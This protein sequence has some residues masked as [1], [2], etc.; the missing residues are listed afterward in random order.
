MYPNVY[1]CI[2]MYINVLQW[3]RVCRPCWCTK[4]E[5]LK[6]YCLCTPIFP[7]MYI[8]VHQC[9]SMYIN[10]HQCTSMYINVP[11][12]Q[13]AC[14]PCWCTKQKNLMKKSIVHVHQCSLQWSSPRVTREKCQMRAPIT[15]HPVK[16]SLD[17]HNQRPC[18][19][20]MFSFCSSGHDSVLRR[21][22][23]DCPLIDKPTTS[24]FKEEEEKNCKLRKGKKSWQVWS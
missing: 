8:N 4:Q 15:C 16:N 19:L 17:K 3:K 18:D 21:S 2:P 20:W 13:R 9:K 23:F 22:K 10:V 5:N 14:R 7:N 11:Q 12:W 6:I 24:L 1:Q